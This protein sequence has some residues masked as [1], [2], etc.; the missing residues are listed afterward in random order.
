MR[1]RRFINA[2]LVAMVLGIWAGAQSPKMERLNPLFVGQT[3]GCNAGIVSNHEGHLNCVNTPI[4]FTT[5]EG[6]AA[7]QRLF[8]GIV[9]GVNAGVITTKPAGG[10]ELA[11]GGV[12]PPGT[13]DYGYTIKEDFKLPESVALYVVIGC[14]KNDGEV[15]TN[16]Y[17][18]NCKTIPI[19][20]TLPWTE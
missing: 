12:I 18:K 20:Y 19:G 15:T 3:P 14:G 10:V 2:L 4:G 16:Q 5:K 6:P 7:E 13:R 11:L 8:L 9:P 17:H 1:N